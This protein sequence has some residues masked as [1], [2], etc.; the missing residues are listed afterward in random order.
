MNFCTFWKLKFTKLTKTAKFLKICFTVKSEWHFMSWDWYKKLSTWKCHTSFFFSKWPQIIQSWKHC[1][2][3]LLYVM[4]DLLLR[5]SPLVNWLFHKSCKLKARSSLQDHEFC[6]IFLSSH[7]SHSIY[8]KD[9]R[10]KERSLDKSRRGFLENPQWE[11][12][13]RTWRA[14]K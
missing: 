13:F 2:L 6:S 14:I 5:K 3:L 11:Q 10:K 9:E 7:S 4:I 12:Y 1:S 8:Y